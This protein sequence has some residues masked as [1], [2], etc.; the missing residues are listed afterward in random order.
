MRHILSRA[1]ATFLSSRSDKSN[2][3]PGARNRREAVGKSVLVIGAGVS[4]LTSALCLVQKGLQAI[5]VADQFAPHITSVAAGALWEWPPAVCGHHHDQ[6]SLERSKSWCQKSYQIFAELSLDPAT[7]V[8]LR[9]V[10][11][12][13][14]Q[15][16]EEIGWRR[17]KMDELKSKVR[18]FRR[19]PGL[20]AENSINPALGLRD[21]YTHLAP[22]V[23]TDV[24]ME[25][26]LREARRSGCRIVERKITG[27]LRD[28]AAALQR[29]YGVDAIVNCSGLG[30]RELAEPSVHPLRGALIRVR[31]DGKAMPRITQAHC[32]S[33]DGSNEKTGFIF[34]V[35]RGHDMLVL[36][37]FAEPDKW[38]L[39]IGLHNYEP[40]REMYRR[41]LEFMPV[42]GAAEVDAAEPVRAGLRPF[43]HQGVRLEREPGTP[44]IHNY[45]HSGSGVTFSWGCAFEVVDL[46][47][48]LLFNGHADASHVADMPRLT[49]SGFVKTP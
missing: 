46:I 3:N 40:I 41:C 14:E 37:G 34:I 6:V 9:P 44:I 39:D 30:A 25:W 33:H 27:V 11:F 12:Y 10:T 4:G 7:G 35:P 1:A 48:D 38:G 23:D 21:A 13:F 24:Y 31:N 45:G 36:G 29:Q 43:R 2:M 8:F 15:P 5:V 49:N 28:Q 19:N 17:A 20:I 22:M 26:L 18:G 32:I 47:E 16:I 42:L